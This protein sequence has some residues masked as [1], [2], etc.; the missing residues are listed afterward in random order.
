MIDLTDFNNLLERV[1]LIDGWCFRRNFHR[2]YMNFSIIVIDF[3]GNIA[4]RMSGTNDM[5]RVAL[6]TMLSCRTPDFESSGE[7]LMFSKVGGESSAI[8]GNRVTFGP[9][10]SMYKTAS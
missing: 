10:T 7:K 5:L 2:F 4:Y 6:Q 1:N 3:I 8:Q 9:V